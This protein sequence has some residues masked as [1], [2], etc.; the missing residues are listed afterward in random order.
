MIVDAA[1]DARY[2]A[3]RDD[4]LGRLLRELLHVGSVIESPVGKVKHIGRALCGTSCVALKCL[5]CRRATE[6]SVLL[7]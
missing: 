4:A 5:S 3:L 7:L 1:G 2:C 6:M